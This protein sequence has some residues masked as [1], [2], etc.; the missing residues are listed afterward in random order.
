MR[1]YDDDQ[2][3]LQEVFLHLLEDTMDQLLDHALPLEDELQI[4]S[5]DHMDEPEV[6]RR[7]Q[8]SAVRSSKY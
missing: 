7:V 5:G 8:M 2:M 1:Y 6:F 3:L 4:L